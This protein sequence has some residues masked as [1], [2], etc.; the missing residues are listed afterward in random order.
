MCRTLLKVPRV[1]LGKKGKAG[2]PPW[3]T[4][5]CELQ[6]RRAGAWEMI[7]DLCSRL[8]LLVMIE[9]GEKGTACQAEECAMV[10]R[11][12]SGS[13]ASPDRLLYMAHFGVNSEPQ[14]QSQGLSPQGG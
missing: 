4:L 12:E 2:A 3:E 8:S 10:R 5:P 1:K 13:T 9:G 11:Q 6:G 7:P 14:D